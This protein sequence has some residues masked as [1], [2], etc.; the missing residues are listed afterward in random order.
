MWTRS[1]PSYRTSVISHSI[2]SVVLCWVSACDYVC[3]LRCSYCITLRYILMVRR[4][5]IKHNPVYSTVLR[6]LSCITRPVYLTADSCLPRSQ[7][8]KAPKFTFMIFLAFWP[9][10]PKISWKLSMSYATGGPVFRS[11]S[12]KSY[13][14]AMMS[15]DKSTAHTAAERKYVITSELTSLLHSNTAQAQT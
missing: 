9:K 11:K 7:E 15:K 5:Q 10:K 14:H 13:I 12:Y 1:V 3:T 8:R 2:S 4:M 6:S